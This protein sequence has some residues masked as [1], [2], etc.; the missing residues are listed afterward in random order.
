MQT[1]VKTKVSRA[2][3]RTHLGA[4]VV[5]ALLPAFAVGAIAV[6]A[7]VDS[8]RRSFED[9]LQNTAAALA[10][11]VGSEIEIYTA[12]LLALS[13]STN[14][15]SDTLDL[16][17]FHERA[18]W[19]A[20]GL[21]SRLFLIKPD[22]T[23]P[24]HTDFPFGTDMQAKRPVRQTSDIA[25]QVFETRRPVVGDAILGQM[26]DRLLTPVYVPVMRSGQ[27]TYALGSVIES[28]RLSRLLAVQG[29]DDGVYASLIDARGSIVARSA[30]QKQYVGQQVRDWVMAGVRNR[31]DGVLTGENLVGARIT[32]AFHHVAPFPGW[33]IMVAAPDATFYASLQTPLATLAL[34]GL[35]SLA[36]ALFVAARL[37]HRVLMPVA[38]LTR[39]A[40]RV[41]SSEGEIEPEEPP[42]RVHEF[43]RLR[44]AVMQAH[45]A[46]Q[47][48]A[49]AVS[50]G[51]ARLRA[52]V[53]TAVDAII[54][55]DSRGLIQSL[56]PAAKTVFGYSQD[57]AIGA[58]M[59][60][61]ISEVS[62]TE[63][64]DPVAIAA[65]ETQGQREAEGYCKDGSVVPIELSIAEWHDEAGRQ[66]FTWIIR[67]ISVRKADEERRVLLAREVDHRAK[68][69]L[70]VVQSVLRLSPRDDPKAFVAAVEARVGALARVH[71]L[72]AERGW[73]GAKLHT[74]VE[75][76][77]AVYVTSCPKVRDQRQSTVVISGPPVALVPEAVQPFA[78]VLHE[79]AT[80][81]A[82]HGAMS[83]PDGR[84]D[85]RWH[86]DITAAS[87]TLWL[88]WIETGGPAIEGNPV[89]RGFGSRVVD[90]TM[91]GQLGGTIE[92]CW[93]RTGLSVEMSV[94]AT[95]VMAKEGR[96]TIAASK[97]T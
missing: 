53:D 74:V 7:A 37:G 77:L 76:E 66:Y 3:L 65:V 19:V 51:E 85:V 41:A 15:D 36:L 9:R 54:V 67:D 78:M 20:A 2:K 62:G 75:Q 34:G 68:N 42:V 29:F 92:R 82:K 28:Q 1:L 96:R 73:G 58:S 52:V 8:Y 16:G 59:T 44:R 46:L 83:V 50:A 22:G 45:Q 4:L 6:S 79:L 5:S 21:A 63:S 26:T 95:R 93:N 17:A 43:E 25:R 32:T 11:A 64:D 13:T 57:E 47:A 97:V 14:L 90:A 84:V 33:T 27:V 40:E 10:S 38:W 91:R 70:A 88:R 72:L 30:D 39:R 81:A 61:L 55:S 60:M 80:N 71:S 35:G 23:M 86:M 56:N 94:P 89:R 49:A 31:N 24:L 48:R 12:S 87:T 69:V 18:G